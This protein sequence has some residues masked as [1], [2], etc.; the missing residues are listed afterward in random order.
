[1]I[2]AGF[3]GLSTALHL[4]EHGANVVVP[5]AHEPGWG[6]SGRNGG[7][8][9]PGLKWNPDDVEKEFGPELGSKLGRY[10]LCRH[11]YQLGHASHIEDERHRARFRLRDGRP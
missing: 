3:T 10:F 5:E 11:C 9:N 6:A 1:M 4:A 8:V 2:G 7:Q